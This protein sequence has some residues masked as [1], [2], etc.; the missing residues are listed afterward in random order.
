MNPQLFEFEPHSPK[1]TSTTFVDNMRLPV[2]RW[3][4]YSAGY[5]AKWAQKVV[6]ESTRDQSLAILDPFCGSGTTLLAAQDAGSK[7]IGLEAHPF[8]FRIAQAKLQRY[9]SVEEYRAFATRVRNVAT[10]NPGSTTG[11]PSLVNRCYSPEFLIELDALR[12]AFE[13]LSDGTPESELTWLTLTS[14]LRKTSHANTAQWQYVLPSKSKALQNVISPMK[15]YDATVEM[16]TA[17]MMSSARNAEIGPSP[18]LHQGDARTCAEVAD[19]SINLVITSPPYPNN[20]DYADATRLEMSFYKQVNG[21]SDLQHSVRR[22]LIRS[23]SQH[24]PQKAVSLTDVLS[25]SALGPI[26]DELASVCNELAQVRLTKGGKKTYHLMVACYF[27]DMAHTWLALRRV[28]A[29]PSE[30]VFVIGD[31]APYGVYVP[32]IDWF[33]KLALAAGF[34]EVFFEKTRERNTKWKNRKHRVPLC[35][36]RLLVKG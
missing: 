3:L 7:G 26:R 24:V 22:H 2:H 11:Y 4:R 28:C 31:S 15:A 18:I 30:A 10:Q 36:G 25:D 21:W 32:V 29:S 9:S 5:S 13:S 19:N 33:E 35:E 27:Q 1:D 16:F 20:Y 12:K 14:L 34:N 17:D 8:V 6:H 23:C